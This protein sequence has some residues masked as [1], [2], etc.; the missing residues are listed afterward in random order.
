MEDIYIYKCDGYLYFL[1]FYFNIRDIDLK[2]IDLIIYI[3]VNFVWVYLFDNKKMLFVLMFF[4]FFLFIEF[5]FLF[6]F[7]IIICKI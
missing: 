6:Y 7:K 1:F 3:L 2:Y 5:F 4:M